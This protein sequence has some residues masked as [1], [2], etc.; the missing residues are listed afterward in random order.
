MFYSDTLLVSIRIFSTTKICK[1]NGYFSWVYGPAVFI[2]VFP[3]GRVLSTDVQVFRALSYPAGVESDPSNIFELDN[4]LF[5]KKSK[6][7]SKKPT[8]KTYKTF[9]DVW[10][11]W[12]W[13][14]GSSW[15]SWRA[16]GASCRDDGRRVPGVEFEKNLKEINRSENCQTSTALVIVRFGLAKHQQVWLL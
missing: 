14:A 1:G 7:T 3:K 6:T 11:F 16:Y 13:D 15:S 8:K 12:M 5:V 4:I 2:R 9:N 10:V